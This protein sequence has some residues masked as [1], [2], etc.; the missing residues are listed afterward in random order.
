MNNLQNKNTFTS[1][2]LVEQ[3]DKQKDLDLVAKFIINSKIPF[4]QFFNILMEIYYD[5][6]LSESML[7]KINTLLYCSELTKVN[8]NFSYLA[9]MFSYML[10]HDKNNYNLS[11]KPHQQLVNKIINNFNKIFPKYTYIT[12]EKYIGNGFRVDILAKD[13]NNTPVLIEVKTNNESPLKQLNLYKNYFQ[14]PILVAF[15]NFSKNC[16]E[17]LLKNSIEVYPMIES[18]EMRTNIA[19]VGGTEN[20]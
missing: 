3:I 6:D 20:E 14:N 7:N 1:L 4:E 17:D 13:E 2:E 16:I 10:K 5:L 15:G 12:K 8:K 19:L 9:F 11:N 18:E